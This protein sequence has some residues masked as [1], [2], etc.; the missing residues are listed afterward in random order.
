MRVLLAGLLG[1]FAMF[2]WAFVAHT[3]TP[4][5]DVGVLPLPHEETILPVLR[6]SL[7]S[8]PKVYLFP[9]GEAA[10][11]RRAEAGPSGVL[12]YRPPGMPAGVTPPRLFGEFIAEVIQSVIVALLLAQTVLRQYAARAGFVALLGLAAA[13]A[14]NATYCLLPGYPVDYTFSYSF[15]DFMRYVAAGLVIAAILRPRP[16]ESTGRQGR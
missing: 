12:V 1:G 10:Q 2:T 3:F 14:T 5:D 9:N 4:L 16:I 8:T 6:E 7:G 13:L 15:M 11:G